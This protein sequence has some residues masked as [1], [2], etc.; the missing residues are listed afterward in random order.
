MGISAIMYQ[1][2]RAMYKA[3]R[4]VEEIAKKL[5]IQEGIIRVICKD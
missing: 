5:D 2:I 4:T 1:K 3:G